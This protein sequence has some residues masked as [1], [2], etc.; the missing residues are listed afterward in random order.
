[1]PILAMISNRPIASLAVL[2]CGLCTIPAFGQ[3]T[4]MIEFS[5][6]GKTQQ[7]LPLLNLAHEMV[8][9]GRDGWMHSLDPQKPESQI[10][11]IESTYQPISVTELRNELRAEFG[12]GFEVI[13]T[14]NFLVVQPEGRGDRWPKLFE[15]SHR[16]FVDYMRKRD[17]T[18]RDGRFPMVAV[19]LADENAMH[20][21][22]KKLGIEVKR[23]AGLYSGES[24][25]V[26][27][28]D[29]GRS[30]QIAATVRHEAAHQSAYNMGVHSRLSPTPRYISEGIGQMFEPAGMT[31]ARSS[32]RRDDR[33]NHDS[34]NFLKRSYVGRDDIRFTQSVMQLVSDDTLFADPKSVEEAYSVAWSI[35]FYLAER[36]SA[37]FAELLNQT[38]ARPPFL[39]YTRQDRVKDFERIVG[40]DTFEFS[41]KVAWF[42]QSI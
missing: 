40:C 16:A 5:A 13:A 32:T 23:V 28:H 9:L 3:T 29:G 14:T 18:V 17:V 22:F 37:K 4:G 31:N 26:M 38:S 12:R 36:D 19:V 6:F 24:N 33:V 35:M 27:T 42:M 39:D 25:R 15:Q 41:K 20:R 7:G 11:R 8:V 21:E 34:L 2:V 30:E 1:M 10:R